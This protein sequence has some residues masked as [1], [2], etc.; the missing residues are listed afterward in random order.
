MKK[1]QEFGKQ[2][3]KISIIVIIYTLL[4]SMIYT[5]GG[6]SKKMARILI[7]I[8]LLFLSFLM[9]YI[10]GKKTEKKGYKTGGKVSLSIL[11]LLTL[12]HILFYPKSWQWMTIFYYFLIVLFSVLGAMIGINKKK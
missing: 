5:W 9:G 1:G 8:G 11:L 7:W 10:K 12:F 6:M 2:I 4:I 3:L